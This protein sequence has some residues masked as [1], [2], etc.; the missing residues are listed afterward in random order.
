M[1]GN[2]IK[3]QRSSRPLESN[4]SKNFRRNNSRRRER[5][6]VAVGHADQKK[7]KEDIR[8]A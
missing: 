3:T 8:G 7:A 6:K 1:N 4:I 5:A 2:G